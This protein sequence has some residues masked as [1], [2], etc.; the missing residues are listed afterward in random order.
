MA[1]IYFITIHIYQ[2]LENYE[3]YGSHGSDY[4]EYHL[5]EC[6]TMQSRVHGITSQGTEL[7]N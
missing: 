5:L 1:L 2:Q 6:D 7:F 3:I 4:E